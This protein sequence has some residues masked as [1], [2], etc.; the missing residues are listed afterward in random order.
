MAGCQRAEAHQCWPPMVTSSNNIMNVYKKIKKKTNKE[1][2]KQ[3][4]KTGRQTSIQKAHSSCHHH[5]K[6]HSSIITVSVYF[7]LTNDRPAGTRTT[8]YIW[9]HNN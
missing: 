5:G 6:S 7:R 4:Y 1:Y 8:K 3:K 2:A 9:N